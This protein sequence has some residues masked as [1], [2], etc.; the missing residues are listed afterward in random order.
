MKPDSVRL[1]RMACDRRDAG[2]FPRCGENSGGTLLRAGPNDTTCGNRL[3]LSHHTHRRSFILHQMLRSLVFR[4][5]FPAASFRPLPTACPALKFQYSPTPRLPT[6]LSAEVDCIRS[7][8][9]RVSIAGQLP[10]AV[11]GTAGLGVCRRWDFLTS[12]VWQ[13][14]SL[15]RGFFFF[16][17][18]VT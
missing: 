17:R 12:D 11:G 15:K 1:H 9:I 8:L 10:T 6:E 16:S 7:V 2:S 18:A 14:I 13:R 5:F 4:K 3:F